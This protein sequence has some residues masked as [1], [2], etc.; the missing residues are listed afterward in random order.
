MLF[1]LCIK[2]TIL[3]FYLMMLVGIAAVYAESAIL[4]LLTFAVG[5]SAILGA[6]VGKKQPPVSVGKRVRLETG[7]RATRKAG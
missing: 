1:N 5:V 7:G 2:N 3:R 4:V 6:C